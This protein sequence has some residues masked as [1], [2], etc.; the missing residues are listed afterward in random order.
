VSPTNTMYVTDTPVVSP[1]NTMF[2]T[3]TPVVSPT[4]TVF[5]TDTPVASVTETPFV[6]T[7]TDTPVLSATPTYTETI[8]LSPTSTRTSTRTPLNTRT[9]TPTKTATMTITETHTGTYTDTPTD[10]ATVTPTITETVTPTITET[11]TDTATET[12]TQTITE[13]VTQTVT[14]TDTFVPSATHTVTLTQVCSATPTVSPTTGA[15]AVA[16]L[17]HQVPDSAAPLGNT[18]TSPDA[19]YYGLDTTLT[20]NTGSRTFGSLTSPVYNNLAADAALSFLSWAE[21]ENSPAV[22]LRN[23]Y[24]SID[25]GTSWSLLSNMAGNENAWLQVVI[26]LGAYAGQ[27]A[28]FRFEFDSVDS[29]A[30]DFRGW[31]VDDVTL[32]QAT[33]TVTPSV[34]ETPVIAAATPSSTLT[35]TVPAVTATPSMTMTPAPQATQAVFTV[36]DPAVYPNPFNPGAGGNLWARYDLSQNVSEAVLKVY[37]NSYRLVRTITLSGQDMNGCGT[38]ISAAGAD[39]LKGLSNGTYYYYIEARSVDGKTARS[40]AAVMLILK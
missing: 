27:D 40:K 39:K 31:Y 12:D 37:T 19:W 14:A 15:W 24:I 23:I 1:T 5:A 38:R 11:I 21:T 32:I 7:E 29:Y 33:P 25:G 35:A 10:T 36:T 13:T 28:M 17:W 34:T 9:G 8:Y 2:V 30:N 18:S 26:G 3:D 4:D 6:P 20:Y 22:D 16:G